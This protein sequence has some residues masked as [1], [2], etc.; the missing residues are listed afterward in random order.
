MGTEYLGTKNLLIGSREL[1]LIASAFAKCELSGNNQ[2]TADY[3][4]KLAAFFG[5]SATVACSSG[6]GGLLM[7]LLA[8]GVGPDDEV[9]VPPTAPSAL[10]IL[11]LGARP[12]FCDTESTQSFALCSRAI[13]NRLTRRTR[14]IISVPMWGYPCESTELRELADTVAL[15]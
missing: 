9:I 14:G 11:A 15:D 3:E 2:T 8:F 13:G 10:P 5:M 6:T 7:S 4:E 1:D 12:V